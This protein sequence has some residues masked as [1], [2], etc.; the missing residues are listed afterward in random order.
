MALAGDKGLGFPTFEYVY[1][2]GFFSCSGFGVG[3]E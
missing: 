3:E 2:A 1:L